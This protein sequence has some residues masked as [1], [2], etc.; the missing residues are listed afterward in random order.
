MT[1]QHLSKTRYIAGL[2]CLRR[3]WLLAH[4]PPPYEEPTPGTPLDIGREIGRK[5]RLLFPGGASIDE[6]PW[7]HAE[8]I[9]RTAALM[10]DEQVP[11]I[12]EAA[13]EYD[14][15]RIR[16]DVLERLAGGT[17]GL[18]EVKSSCGPKDYYFDDIALQAFVLEKAGVALSSIE[19]LHVN[20]TYIRGPSGIC[21][22]DFFTRVD[23]RDSLAARLVDL[24]NRLTAMRD[25]LGMVERPYAEPGGQCGTPYLCEFWDQCT[26]GK[27]GDWIYYLPACRRR[28]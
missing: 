24:P 28:T 8:A 22:E 2:Q 7:R 4:E 9:G 12:F 14:N 5:A 23:V 18:R 1:S 21:W 3:L 11:A 6:E 25:C 26:A 19:L 20:A 15:I 17:W 10:N 16:V 27:P 13:F